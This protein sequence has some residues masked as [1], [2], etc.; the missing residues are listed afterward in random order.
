MLKAIE[1]MQQYPWRGRS[2][3]QKSSRKEPVRVVEHKIVA[4][5]SSEGAQI[6][7]TPVLENQYYDD[8]AFT[9]V[10]DLFLPRAVKDMAEADVAAFAGAVVSQQVLGWVADAETHPPYLRHWDMWGESKEG[11]IT[12]EGWKNL[13]KFG[14][15]EG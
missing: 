1:H 15:S 7:S 13:W 3:V 11:V 2:P 12:S 6:R 5:G 10:L 9:R 14:I 4:G 8:V